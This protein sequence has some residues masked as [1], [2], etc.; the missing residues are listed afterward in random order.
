MCAGRWGRSERCARAG[1]CGQTECW[2]GTGPAGLGW[3]KESEPW[4]TSGFVG[5]IGSGQSGWAGAG[6]SLVLGLFS[7]SLFLILKQTKHN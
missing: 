2:G 5:L 4:A 7:I 1:R 3:K 6:L